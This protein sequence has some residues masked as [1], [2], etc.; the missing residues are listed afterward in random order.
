[1]KATLSPAPLLLTICLVLG[2]QEAKAQGVGSSSD[3]TG[4]VTDPAGANVP[5]ARVTIVDAAK[6][7][8]RVVTTDE[9]GAYRVSGL[10]PTT[11]QVSAEHDGFQTEAINGV[12]LTVG[13]TLVLDFHLKL[14]GTTS[15]VEVSS[16]L[17]VVETQRGSQADT[18]TQNYVEQLPIN[19][20][21]YLAFTL[22][23]PGVSNSNT[24]ADNA[25]FRVKQTPQSGLSFY[26][27]NGRGNSVTVDGGEA[28]DDAGGVRLTLSQDAVQEFQ[29]NRS[30]YAA[31]LGGASGATI[32]IVSKSGTNDLHANLFA[33]FRN[34]ALDARDRFA[35]SQ[36]LQ[37]GEPFSLTAMG[38]PIKN[39]L[40]RQQFGGNA[41]FPVSKDKSFLYVAYEGLLSDAQDSVPLL[42]NSNIFAPTP[43]QQSIISKLAGEGARPVP[44]ITTNPSNPLMNPLI[45]SADQCAFALGSILTLNPNPG[46]NP[47]V[48]DAQRALNPY[49][50]NQFEVN[51]GLFPF[52]TH[53][54]QFS[55]RFDHQFSESDQAFLRYSFVHL[56]EKSPDVQA[57]TGFSR[58]TSELAWDSTLQGSW[59]HQ[60]NAGM[61]NE[62]TIQWNWYQFNVDTNDP[63]GPGHDVEGYGFFGRGIFLPSHTTARRYL[64][65]DN[66]TLVRGHHTMKMG[67]EVLIRGNNTSS[68]TFFPARFEFLQLPGALLSLCLEAPAACGLPA[69][70]ASSSISTLQSWSLGLP[71]FFEQGFGNPSYIETRPFTGL[72]WQDSWRVNPT[73]TLNYGLRYELDSQYGPL[74]TPGTNFAPRFSFAWDPFND[75]KTVIRGGY[76]IFYSQIYAQIG[77]VVNVL[78]NVNDTRRIANTLVSILGNPLNPAVTSPRIFQT[79]FFEG[80]NPAD[81]TKNSIIGCGTPQPG[82]YACI[83]PEMLEQN[84]G[85]VV[86]NTGPLPPGTVLFAGQPNYKS[87]MSQQISVGI[88]R[89]LGAGFSVS[90]NYIYVHTTHL[91][92]ALDSNLLPGAP[93]CPTAGVVTCGPPGLGANGLPTNGLPFQN[94]GAPTCAANPSLC[95]ADPTHVILQNNVYS[96][97]ASALFQGGLLEVKKA[98]S[99]HFTIL[100]NYTY[101][102]ATD[103]ATDFNSDYSPFNATCLRCDRSLSDFD[104]RHKVVLAGVFE[105]P[106]ENSKILSGFEFAPILSYNSSHPFNL[107]AGADINGDGHFTNDRPPAAGRNTGIGPSYTNLDLR[108]SRTF[109]LGEK[110]NMQL[111]AEAFNVANHTN[112]ASVNNIVGAAFGPPFNVHGT[113]NVGPSQPLGFTAAFPNREIQLGV[114]LTF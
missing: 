28:N 43:T 101:S 78:G 83:T 109:K 35:M 56:T 91:P 34:D 48:N 69:S 94:W 15:M 68:Q 36:A 33:Y 22:L 24:I 21:S 79:L 102:R 105:S 92:V 18:I 8:K 12:V 108:L 25:D 70:Q 100:A 88:E 51:G 26:G 17:P 1:M 10:A 53:Q 76:G 82:Q 87:P 39:S 81:P 20:R 19:Q 27:S 85:L 90:A 44:C 52:P 50:V 97:A 113:A 47:F 110:L 63:G 3:L 71:A 58:G 32:N 99:N 61:Q 72:Y 75:H 67:F 64:F 9:Q 65:A 4:T 114:R 38:V 14:A 112:Y 11:Y 55:A 89:A 13:Q 57:L 49:I 62:A 30:N 5:N 104:Q 42:T 54:H 86:P 7:V 80:F 107:L 73:L 41:G 60:F 46:P 59:F 77:N 45:L 66:L 93:V 29:V 84:F 40:N 6:G 111:T 74:H 103:N 23:A 98:F 95:F 16:E 31:D 96:S 106:W 2:S 37:P